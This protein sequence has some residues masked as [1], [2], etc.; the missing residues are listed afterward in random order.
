[1]PQLPDLTLDLKTTV[2]LITICT[3]AYAVYHG[4][5][6]TLAQQEQTI[7]QLRGQV[8][9]MTVQQRAQER[10]IIELTVSLKARNVIP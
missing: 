10:A 9:E 4:V 3:T 6:L 8:S 2:L 7:Q 1:M 5:T